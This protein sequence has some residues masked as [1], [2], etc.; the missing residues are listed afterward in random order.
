MAQLKKDEQNSEYT[1]SV[2]DVIGM[3]VQAVKSTVR[4]VKDLAIKKARQ[5][6][7]ELLE[8][9]RYTGPLK[10]QFGK[11]LEGITDLN[12]DQKN[13]VWNMIEQ[14]LNPKTKVESVTR[15]S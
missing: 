13:E 12:I 11:A 14:L 5:W 6:T 1:C 10:K 9:Y 4:F 7:A 8:S 15:F 3:L 2:E